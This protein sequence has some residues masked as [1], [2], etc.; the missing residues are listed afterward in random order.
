MVAGAGG[1]RCGSLED[2]FITVLLEIGATA[3]SRASMSSGRPLR[4]ARM[5]A[6]SASHVLPQSRILSTAAIASGSGGGGGLFLLGDVKIGA[7]F[8]SQ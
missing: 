7:G 8:F 6:A 2:V 4:H 3:C 5:S 1:S